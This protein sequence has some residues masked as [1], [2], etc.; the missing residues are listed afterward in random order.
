MVESHHLL[1]NQANRINMKDIFLLYLPNKR[2]IF[3]Y[4]QNQQVFNRIPTNI[5]NDSR[6][7]YFPIENDLKYAGF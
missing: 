6:L 5:K 2:A 1:E 3:R 4:K 7:F